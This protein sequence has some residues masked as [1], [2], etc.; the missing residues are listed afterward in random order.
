[1]KNMI[2]QIFGPKMQNSETYIFVT[3]GMFILAASF[4]TP[5]FSQSQQKS[6]SIVIHDTTKAG[7]GGEK[8]TEGLRNQ[9]KSAL[10]EDKPCVE[11]MDD[12]DL[13]DAIQDERER[14][15][16]E[17][18][19]LTAA[20]KAIGERLNSQFVMSVRFKRPKRQMITAQRM[21]PV[22]K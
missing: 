1:M 3:L 8:A 16:M 18:G 12:Q 14:E 10:A 11:T 5:A 7:N 13:R 15:L 6:S 22:E 20:L 9:F 4:A 19:D 17:G 21:Q 2:Y